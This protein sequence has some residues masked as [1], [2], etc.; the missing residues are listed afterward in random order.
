MKNGRSS[1][2]SF[3]NRSWG[4]DFSVFIVVLVVYVI[5]VIQFDDTVWTKSVIQIIERL[6][7][8]IPT[9]IV[10]TIVIETLRHKIMG[11]IRDLLREEERRKQEEYRTKLEQE[12]RDS[13]VEETRQQTL[14][15]NN[16]A[17]EEWNDRR[18]TAEK[19]NQRF[20]DPPPSH[21]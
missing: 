7:G 15:E 3:A 6:S 5:L 2:F 20:I 4:N 9:A 11:L 10:L 21:P 18:I 19:N 16:K 17:W 8:F 1:V 12:I 13:V 14:Y